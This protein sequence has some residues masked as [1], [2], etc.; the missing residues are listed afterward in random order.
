MPDFS[1]INKNIKEAEWLTVINPSTGKPIDDSRGT[2]RILL[3]NPESRESLKSQKDAQT[4]SLKSVLGG[5]RGSGGADVE[6]LV[7]SAAAL[8]V[9]ATVELENVEFEGH[10]VDSPD[11]IR[12][13]YDA[14]GWLCLQVDEFLN[15]RSNFLGN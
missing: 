1:N 12:R 13:L 3:R 15:D 10:S 14:C 7:E 6:G 2:V 8:R 9:A 5:R 4:K 11:D